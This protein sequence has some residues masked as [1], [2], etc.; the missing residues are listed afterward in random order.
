MKYQAAVLEDVRKFEVREKT[1]RE[2]KEGEVVVKVMS[3][4]IC[5]SD[6]T[7]VYESG[8]YSKN[9]V[10]GHE[11]AG[12]AE[13]KRVAVY[14]I[15]P[16]KKCEFCKE[17]KYNLC[18]NYN[19]L[20]SRTD[21]GF[22][23]ICIAPKEN[24]VEIPSSISFDEAALIEPM[25]V[26]LSGIKKLDK[27]GSA[28]ILG[29]G[30]VGILAGILCKKMGAQVNGVDRNPHK[31]LIA[32]KAGFDTC[33]KKFSAGMTDVMIDCSGSSEL[34]NKYV[35]CIKK[36]GS[37]LSLANYKND[38]ALSPKTVSTM[39]RG[40]MKIYYSWNSTLE[41]WG[42]CVDYISKREADVIPLITHKFPLRGVVD[43]FD[44][45]YHKKI[46]YLK[47]I[48]NPK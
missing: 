9:L 12:I 15:I 47:V 20:G 33:V 16:C 3:C 8:M 1:L 2:L 14:P 42:Q 40:E 36:G 41:E 37:I 4:G 22:A 34:F 25:A 19:Y 28:L 24:L 39:L 30:P 11:F 27:F 23:K 32:K 21:G 45:V 18:K 26:A 31:Y 48:I 44:K 43:A 35:G 6:L 38:L 17:K 29:L 13:G 7:R 46:K 5:G 10:P